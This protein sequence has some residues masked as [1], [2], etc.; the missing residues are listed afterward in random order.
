[1]T[2]MFCPLPSVTVMFS[3]NEAV[4]Q[5]SPPVTRAV[6]KVFGFVSSI[7]PP[8]RQARVEFIGLAGCWLDRVHKDEP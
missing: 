1:M 4:A 8:S 5:T 3:A 6:R 7:A 2:P